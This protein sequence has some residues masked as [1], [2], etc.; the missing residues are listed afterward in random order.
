MLESLMKRGGKVFRTH[1]GEPYDLNGDGGGRMK[2]AVIG[3][4]KRS[5]PAL[6]EFNT[7]SHPPLLQEGW[8]CLRRL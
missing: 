8:D 6:R 7:H 2:T 5:V 4:R 1:R 3:A